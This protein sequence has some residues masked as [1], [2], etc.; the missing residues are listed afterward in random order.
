MLQ[1]LRNVNCCAERGAS[2]A[3]SPSSTRRSA[4]I[5]SAVFVKLH[6]GKM[7]V[8]APPVPASPEVVTHAE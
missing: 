2:S 4:Q 1:K 3:R 7:L 8:A 6:H 5:A